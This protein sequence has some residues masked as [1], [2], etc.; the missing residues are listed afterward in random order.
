VSF[1]P[2]R[3][4]CA[5]VLR[6][7]ESAAFVRQAESAAL[8]R[9]AAPPTTAAVT[10]A[11]SAAPYTMLDH[12]GLPV[13]QNCGA[14][15]AGAVAMEPAGMARVD[16]VLISARASHLAHGMVR[17]DITAALVPTVRSSISLTCQAREQ[18]GKLVA[19]VE[20]RS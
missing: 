18:T 3:R 20:N 5:C 7:A 17:H 12:D 19:T 16:P 2:A 4:A 15:V 13:R 10:T 9:P 11:D 1:V 6:R 14:P 8:S